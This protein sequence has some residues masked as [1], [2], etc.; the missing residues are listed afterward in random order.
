MNAVADPVNA[1][2]DASSLIGRLNYF[3]EQ[4]PHHE[5]VVT[6]DYRLTYQGLQALVRKQ[7][8]IYMAQGLS[9]HAIVAISC[10]DDVQHLIHCLAAAYI[11]AT[12]CT[13]PCHDTEQARLAMIARSGATVV[14]DQRT[15]VGIDA[16]N[17]L[18]GPECYPPP[19][20]DAQL[21]F[22]TSGTTGEPKLVQLYSSDIVA[23]AHRHIE[24]NVLRFA[25][26]A[27]MEHNFSRRHRLYCVAVGACNVF[28]GPTRET[29]VQ[30]CL[31]LDVNV[32]H[33]SAF[34]AQEL[35]A[36]PDIGRLA[37]IRLKL[38][39]SHVPWALRQKLRA[40]ITS[41]LQAGYGTTETGAIA[42]T[43]PDDA[44][45]GE[46]VGRALPGIEIRI[47]S[48][49]GHP[50][51]EGQRGELIVR[52]KGLFRAYHDNPQASAERLRDGWFHTG[53]TG[54]LD[55]QGRIHLSG[56]ADDMFVFNSMN[57]YPQDI[58]SVIRRFPGVRDAAVVPRK[59]AV[60]GD[61]PV[62]L[63]VF[64]TRSK[65]QEAALKAFVQK[66][67]GLRSPR[68]YMFVPEIPGNAA[69][70]IARRDA[71]ALPE[72]SEQLRAD[73]IA[74]L[75]AGISKHLKPALIKAFVEGDTDIRIKDI[76]LTS[77]ARMNLLI[78]LEMDY[79]LIITPKDFIEFRYLGD[80]VSFILCPAASEQ[81]Q[82]DV[83]LYRGKERFDVTDPLSSLYSAPSS[84][85]YSAPSSRPYAA[86][87]SRPYVI[88]FFQRIVDCCTTVAQLNQ[89]LTTLEHRLTPLDIDCL[90]EWYLG[91]VLLTEESPE[92]MHRAVSGWLAELSRL[93]DQ[94]GKSGCEPF[95]AKRVAPAM[96]LYA[97]P[98]TAAGK[99]LLLCF[100][101]R[102]YR[103][104]VM[105]NAVF[106][107]H[108]DASRFD[109][110]MIA[111]SARRRFR[112]GL[113]PF[114]RPM[115]E[116]VNELCGLE[117]FNAYDAV[118]TLGFSAG[119]YPAIVTAF[120]LKAEAAFSIS[121]R[122]FTKKHRLKNLETR[123]TLR[124]AVRRGQCPHVYASFS[125]D[126]RRDDDYADFVARTAAARKLIV[127]F[128]D[129][130]TE[131]LMLQQLLER[132]DL[133][134][135]LDA[136]VFAD[137]NRDSALKKND[138]FMLRLQGSQM[139]LE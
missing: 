71:I 14:L 130:N 126:N 52:C 2:T 13:L 124:R 23:Q 63:V 74:M 32:L 114:G 102:G 86:P 16:G 24:S 72:K 58:E 51:P 75:G 122:F 64:D 30:Q 97:A 83:E 66:Q 46:S 31:L 121:G 80:I 93:M 89:A 90:K 132:G 120:L 61:I 18:A 65:Q 137:F 112:R 62:A 128:A 28:L 94:S 76:G 118:R 3:A 25:C 104:L 26:L 43:D 19:A 70:K 127:K 123:N 133:L 84:R 11:G 139:W 7:A 8:A 15:S 20:A 136:S 98:G 85:P 10:A 108:T 35:L 96:T 91:G 50:L 60:H 6:P 113:P 57:I 17:D 69:G 21:L 105:A 55:S 135:Y 29:L 117:C 81:P 88:R 82:Q 34:Q 39:G 119:A 101:P 92:K 106:L 129:R 54:Y 12:A 131:H 47:L 111:E 44:D 40:T 138:G 79:D 37:H 42:F 5:A 56:R 109:V 59:S 49:D 1:M 68:Q 45:A 48:A 77:L 116:L 107:Q 78:A 110:L 36:L 73:I 4:Y 103:R 33:V 27:S 100:P 38:G 67:V 115:H 41:H 125:A 53:D 99:T 95:L 22:T 87:S 9:A 134:S